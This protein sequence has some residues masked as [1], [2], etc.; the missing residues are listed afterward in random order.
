MNLLMN[1]INILYYIINRVLTGHGQL[2]WL[3]LHNIFNGQNDIH[4]LRRHWKHCVFICNGMEV[5][6]VPI[7]QPNGSFFARLL[8]FM[9]RVSFELKEQTCC[10][11][12]TKCR[13][14]LISLYVHI[15]MSYTVYPHAIGEHLYRNVYQ[16]KY[17]SFVNLNQMSF[18]MRFLVACLPY[19][20][21]KFT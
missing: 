8:C 3:N 2:T 7:K 1:Y 5:I 9:A 14:T 15:Q 12:R 17:N 18:Q 16:N 21:R 19:A 6:N 11:G 10:Q 4:S 13:T 20:S